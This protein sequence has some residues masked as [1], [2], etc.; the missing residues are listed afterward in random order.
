MFL[1]HFIQDHASVFCSDEQGDLVY[2]AAGPRQE[3]LLTI[4]NTGKT[5]ETY[6]KHADEQTGRV[7]ISQ[8]NNPWQQAQHAWLPTDLL[9]TLWGEPS[10]TLISSSAVPTAGRHTDK[11]NRS[12]V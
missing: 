10:G 7:E 2:F 5:R 6:R 11:C 3:P 12:D 9:Q 1:R 8:E 4:A